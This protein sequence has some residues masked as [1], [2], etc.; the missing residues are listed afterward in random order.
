MDLSQII[1]P[2][3]F[4]NLSP[5][6]ISISTKS[7]HVLS[8]FKFNGE[9]DTFLS[10]H[11]NDFLRFCKS[12][13]INDEDN[14]FILFTLILEGWVNWWCHTL[15]Y[16]FIHYFDQ[17]INEIH[18]DFDGYDYQDVYKRINHLK[19]E[20]NESIED[21]SNIFLHLCCEFPEED[22]DWDLF[23]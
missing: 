16:A 12:H 4:S 9:G 11:T 1:I 20:P 5:G 6:K 17:F 23:K 19:M 18:Q 15:P 10:K 21:F 8:Q 13:E 7:F 3:I 2:N 14:V 22:M